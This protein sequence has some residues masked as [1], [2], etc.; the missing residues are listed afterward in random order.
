MNNTYVLYAKL[1]Y[2]CENV[3]ELHILLLCKILNDLTKKIEV[4]IS[5]LLLKDYKIALDELYYET[6]FSNYK[7]MKS[8]NNMIY[9][10]S[11]IMIELHRQ[12]LYYL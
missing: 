3:N 12:L 9:I 2:I 10:I 1:R 4:K 5:P 6:I 8:I 7:N 11:I